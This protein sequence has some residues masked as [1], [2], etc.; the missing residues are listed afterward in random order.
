[1]MIVQPFSSRLMLTERRSPSTD[2]LAL[3]WEV[4]P[5]DETETELDAAPWPL[6][7]AET[8]PTALSFTQLSLTVP[9]AR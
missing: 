7:W 3:E 8:E 2:E 4:P 5:R 1:M 6:F 9:S